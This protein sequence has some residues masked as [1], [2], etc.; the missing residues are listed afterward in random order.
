MTNFNPTPAVCTPCLLHFVHGSA[1]RLNSA[2]L[3]SDLERFGTPETLDRRESLADVSGLSVAV[4]ETN[5][6]NSGM[7]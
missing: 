2:R 3:G 1:V 4:C 6:M 7:R 5:Y